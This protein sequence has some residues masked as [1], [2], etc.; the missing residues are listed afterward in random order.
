VLDVVAMFA[1]TV[2]WLPERQ[3]NRL[4]AELKAGKTRALG[5]QPVG[6]LKKYIQEKIL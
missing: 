4:T 6:S 3:G 2:E 1:K 5:W